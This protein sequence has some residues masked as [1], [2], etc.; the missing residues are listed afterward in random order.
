[1]MMASHNRPN[2]IVIQNKQFN[3][4]AREAGVNPKNPGASQKKLQVPL[5][6]EMMFPIFILH[7]FLKM[8]LLLLPYPHLSMK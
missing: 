6:L 5:L 8:K 3:A 1:M 2:N 4:A 7:R